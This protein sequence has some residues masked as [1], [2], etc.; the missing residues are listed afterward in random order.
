MM[1]T[2]GYVVAVPNGGNAEFLRDG[3]NCLLYSRGDIEA[4][5]SCVNRIVNDDRLRETL[6]DEGLKTAE[7]RDWSKLTDKVVSLYD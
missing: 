2:G 7:E 5:V 4:A 1:A 6:Y 3:S